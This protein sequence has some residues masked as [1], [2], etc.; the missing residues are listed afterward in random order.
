[1]QNR[2]CGVLTCWLLLA[3][4]AM[5]C[6]AEGLTSEVRPF[7]GVPALYVNGVLTSQTLAAPYRDPQ[8]SGLDDFNDFRRT[9]ISIF[10]IYV[11]FP[12]TA[13][14]T[15]D[16]APVDRKLD[17]YLAV[18]PKVLFLPRILLTPGRWF[19]EQFPD[20][21]SRRDDGT[22]AGMFPTQNAGNNPSFSSEKYR[23]LSHQ[24]MI[25]FINHLESKYGE[26]IVGY[27]VGNGFGGE[28]L[29]FN[30]FWESRPA[31]RRR[32][33]LASKIILPLPATRLKNG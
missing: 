2:L 26:H 19:R 15:Y 24:A 21:I 31:K 23:E 4:F 22:P 9:G 28:W 3:S 7:K 8:R 1:M 17:A 6:G 5:R 32:R 12:W 27:Q 20:D 18:D 14:E 11:R 10:D 29:P 13:P 25:A 33:S 16:F 30:S